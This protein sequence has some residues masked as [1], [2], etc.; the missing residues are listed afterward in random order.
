[1]KAIEGIIFV[2]LLILVN[3]QVPSD[4]AI[5]SCGSKKDY[6]QPDRKE[7]CKAEGEICCFVH[8]TQKDDD[9]QTIK[10]FCA[11]SP[12]KILKEDIASEIEDYTGYRLKELSC[13]NSK[14]IKNI[15]GSL[16]LVLFTFF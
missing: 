14:Y 1:M 5:N 7:D 6:S 2:L 13:N 16:F 4:K 15:M 8:L 3:S 9:T 11:S 10:K 12:S